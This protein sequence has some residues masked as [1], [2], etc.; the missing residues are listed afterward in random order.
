MDKKKKI[1]IIIASIL[2]VVITAVGLFFV[3]NKDSNDSIVSS[4]DLSSSSGENNNDQAIKDAES[5]KPSK[6]ESQKQI[7]KMKSFEDAHEIENFSKEQVQ[8]ILGL[9]TDY[10]YNSLANTYFLSGQWVEDGSPNV[11]DSVAGNYFTSEVR[12]NIKKIDTN[13]E[14]GS[15]IDTKVFPIVFYIFPNEQ[16][17][18]S[19]SCKAAGSVKGT[20]P[21]EV[22][23][24]LISG[25]EFTEMNYEPTLSGE[26]PGVMVKF[27]ATVEIPV[28]LNG[29]DASIEIRNDYQLNFVLNENFD[30]ETNPNKFVISFYDVQTNLGAVTPL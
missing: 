21:Q 13:P 25:P 8:E 26:I 5:S 24:C 12:E 2:V 27:S 6:E 11:L 20:D 30:E 14:T 3:I 1:S 28:T 22:K 19:E 17:G 7:D 18:T 23:S 4:P 29:E 10:T 16:V 9:A 15:Q